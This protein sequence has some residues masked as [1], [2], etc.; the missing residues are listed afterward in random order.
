MLKAIEN[1]LGRGEEGV[2]TPDMGGKGTTE[3]FWSRG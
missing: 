1:V 2:V 3:S